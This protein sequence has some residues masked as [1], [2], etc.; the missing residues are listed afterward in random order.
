MMRGWLVD[1]AIVDHFDEFFVAKD[2]SQSDTVRPGALWQNKYALRL[3]MLPVFVP[4]SVA[5]KILLVGKSIEFLKILF[6]GP[7][8]FCAP[9]CC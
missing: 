4:E 5:R 1:G 9:S 7:L 3:D 2:P 6:D 8:T